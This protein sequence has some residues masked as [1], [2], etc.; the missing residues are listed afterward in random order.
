M[1]NHFCRRF[2]FAT[3]EELR[4]HIAELPEAVVT[5]DDMKRGVSESSIN[6]EKRLTAA[7]KQIGI[8]GSRVR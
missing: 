4:S 1:T 2:V 5:D 6:Y 3:N 8:D 7:G